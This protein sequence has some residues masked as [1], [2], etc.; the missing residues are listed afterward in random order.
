M[1]VNKCV[2]D[3]PNIEIIKESFNSPF[4]DI[5]GIELVKIEWGDRKSVV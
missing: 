3:K 5:L 4:N 1:A 2:N